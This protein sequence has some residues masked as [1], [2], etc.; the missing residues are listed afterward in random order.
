MTSPTTQ[1]P[2]ATA[3]DDD[4][5]CTEALL[6]GTLALMSSHAQACC[7]QHREAIARKVA[8]RLQCLARH[9]AFTPHFRATLENLLPCWLRQGGLDGLVDTRTAPA[10]QAP[11]RALWHT[12]PEAL[13]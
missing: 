2:T 9:D 6:A 7:D 8:V 1:A 11:A 13:Q 10:P 4:V 5:A 3:R 12:A